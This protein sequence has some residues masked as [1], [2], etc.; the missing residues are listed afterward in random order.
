MT[1]SAYRKKSMK[2]I[3][4]KESCMHYIPVI[5]YKDLSKLSARND[6]ILVTQP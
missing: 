4:N 5:C 3:Y 1:C 2:R 6:E